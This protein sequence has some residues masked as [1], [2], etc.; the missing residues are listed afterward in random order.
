[1][2]HPLSKS[3]RNKESE[4]AAVRFLRLECNDVKLTRER[5]RL[6]KREKRAALLG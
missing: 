3:A 5:E 6:R 4:D 1:M 2:D